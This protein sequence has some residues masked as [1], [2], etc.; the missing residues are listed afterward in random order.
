MIRSVSSRKPGANHKVTP[1]SAPLPGSR[2]P[3]RR[4]KSPCLPW[5][6]LSGVANATPA[7]GSLPILSGSPLS[8]TPAVYLICRTPKAQVSPMKSSWLQHG[9]F[10]LLC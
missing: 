5:L 7:T 9:T 3:E 10:S 1:T 6:A 4:Q 8:Q 2:L